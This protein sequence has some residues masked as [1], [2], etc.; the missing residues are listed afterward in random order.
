[1]K[2]IVNGVKADVLACDLAAALEELGYGG[3]AVATALNE[4]FVPGALRASTSLSNGDRL[5]IVAPKQG[6]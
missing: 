2:I 6:G 5:E 1:M 4:A 3:A